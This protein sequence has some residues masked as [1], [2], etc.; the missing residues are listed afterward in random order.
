MDLLEEGMVNTA[1]LT[2]EGLANYN[3]VIRNCAG[4]QDTQFH[5]MLRQLVEPVLIHK[6][7]TKTLDA[8]FFKN[9]VV[10]HHLPVQ[11]NNTLFELLFMCENDQIQ[12]PDIEYTPNPLLKLTVSGLSKLLQSIKFPALNQLADWYSFSTS[13][14]QNYTLQALQ[15]S[16]VDTLAVTL[17]LLAKTLFL[18]AESSLDFSACLEEM[19]SKK[20]RGFELQGGF[21]EVVV[22]VVQRDFPNKDVFLIQSLGMAALMPMLLPLL[23]HRLVETGLLGRTSAEFLSKVLLT[24]LEVDRTHALDFSEYSK[25][26]LT[27]NAMYQGFHPARSARMVLS[28]HLASVSPLHPQVARLLLNYLKKETP[29]VKNKVNKLFSPEEQKNAASALCL[30]VYSPSNTKQ[31]YLDIMEVFKLKAFEAVTRYLLEVL[32]ARLVVQHWDLLKEEVF[33][34]LQDFDGLH[35]VIGS[36]LYSLA[37]ASSSLELSNSDKLELVSHLEPWFATY[38]TNHQLISHSIYL[39]LTPPSEAQEKYPLLFE[40]AFMK[41]QLESQ[42]KVFAGVDPVHACSFAGLLEGDAH[43]VFGRNMLKE[44]PEQA[45]MDAYIEKLSEFREMNVQHKPQKED[46]MA[47]IPPIVK[48]KR[49]V[50]MVASLIDRVP[51]L[52]GLTRTCEVLGIDTLVVNNKQAM[53]KDP[54]YKKITVHAHRHQ[55]IESIPAGQALK[56]YLYTLKTKHHYKI[57]GLEQTAQSVDIQASSLHQHECV[58]IV[59]GMER[60]GIPGDLLP[61]MDECVEIPQ[62]GVTRSLNVHV[63]GSIALWELVVRSREQED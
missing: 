53:F 54:E 51:N 32:L 21:V 62:F 43:D 46:A 34:T 5:T 59:L 38:T 57:I 12:V 6:L 18:D 45:S 44:N 49:S 20:I 52:A 8:V 28:Q 23:T 55:H 2:G 16:S 48:K 1:C 27:R 35:G 14:F 60:E 63:S 58:A 29:F 33:S 3:G 11:A 47:Y 26:D 40:N 31:V 10:Y 36:L 17:Q 4:L 25:V 7:S 9:L 22:G 39:S 41:A 37:Y 56:D 61:L 24:T 50:I 30:L 19:K 15:V 13:T 42:A